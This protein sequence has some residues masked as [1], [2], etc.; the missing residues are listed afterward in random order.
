VSPRWG[1]YG[2]RALLAVAAGVYLGTCLDYRGSLVD[3]V[4]IGLRYARNLVEGQGLVFNPGERVEGY[5]SFLHVLF[6][7]LLIRLGLDP[8]AG[9]AA[10]SFAMALLGFVVLCRLER[11]ASRPASPVERGLPPAALLLVLALPATAHWSISGMETMLFAALL[12]AAI[13]LQALEEEG[14]R[15]RGATLAFVLLALTR[16]EGVLAFAAAAVGSLVAARLRDVASDPWRRSLRRHAADLAVFAVL[17]GA[18]FAWRARYY[19][20]LFPNTFYA[21]ATGGEGQLTDGLRY[22]GEWA[23]VFPLLA[24][25]SLAPLVPL[26]R[27]GRAALLAA[28]AALPSACVV[29]AFV[30]YVAWVGGDWMDFFRFLFPVLPLCALLWAWA[31][32]EARADASRRTVPPPWWARLRT[33]AAA[34]VLTAACAALTDDAERAFVASRVATVGLRAGEWMR[35]EL[36]P[37]ALI[38]LNTAGAMPWASRLPAV[39]MLGL[40]DEKIAHRP[41]FV[42]SPGWAGHRRG[43]GEYILSRRPR[44]ILFCHTAGAPFPYY[45]SDRELAEEPAFRFFYRLQRVVLEPEAGATERVLGRFLGAP[46]GSGG[47]IYPDLGIAVRFAPRPWPHTVIRESSVLVHYFELDG[48]AET[49]WPH[50]AELRQDPHRFL[51]RAL[52]RWAKIRAAAPAADLAAREEVERLS[53]QA[54]ALLRRG[55]RDAA[56]RLLVAAIGL[57][58]RARSPLPHQYMANLQVMNGRLFA[59]VSAQ[60]AA[61]ELAPEIHLYRENLLALL[62][63]PYDDRFEH[64][65]RGDDG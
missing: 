21:K 41:V 62:L 15:W 11:S 17:Y 53:H 18:Y 1:R 8:V 37:D 55:E 19:G 27:R 54:H 12:L 24:L 52:A 51:A 56:L 39:D 31:W 58:D 64:R 63:R 29:L 28:P 34:W 23:R 9:T 16:P 6:A 4:F 36:P 61:L 25:A 33:L 40:T 45:L 43:W 13:H 7:A 60:K 49:L 32:R 26:A 35:R 42:V 22:V 48:D 44:I 47:R 20:H 50:R 10:L 38:A 3:D 57:N 65:T 5:T 59:A 14:G 46:F 30:V 2:S